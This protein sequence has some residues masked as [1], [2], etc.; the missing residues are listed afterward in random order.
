MSCRSKKVLDNGY[1]KLINVSGSDEL[2]A[3]AARVSRGAQW[4]AYSSED[5]GKL[6]NRLVDWEH[7]TPFEF[8]DVVFEVK[9]PIYIARQWMRHR[10]FTYM[11][12]SGRY[13]YTA[14][15][16]YIPDRVIEKSKDAVED[17]AR[18]Y[19][20]LVAADI[21]QQDVRSILPLGTYTTF[22]FKA[23]LRNL[24]HF[25]NL[26]ASLAAQPEMQDYANAIYDIVKHEFPQTIHAFEEYCLNTETITTRAQ[27]IIQKI[28]KMTPNQEEEELVTRQV[29]ETYP[30]LDEFAKAKLVHE[31]MG[32]LL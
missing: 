4:T 6:I 28:W 24:L 8:A 16:V 20:D 21:H 22:W 29:N 7:Y 1:V 13:N 27:T 5:N 32:F 19:A 9:C 11:E 14:F 25:V 18:S 17:I 10:T 3:R 12:K 15:D 30:D 23:D 26:R 31:V 2:I